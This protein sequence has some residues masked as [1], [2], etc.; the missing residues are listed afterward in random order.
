MYGVFPETDRGTVMAGDT[1]VVLKVVW[2]LLVGM[3]E[4]NISSIIT[5]LVLFYFLYRIILI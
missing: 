5:A 1:P 3:N 4:M 2:E